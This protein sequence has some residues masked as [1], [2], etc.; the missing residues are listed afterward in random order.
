MLFVAFIAPNTYAIL[1]KFSWIAYVFGAFLLYTGIKLARQHAVEVH[2]E[3]NPVLN[4]IRRFMPITK[5]YRGQ[6]MFVREN[7]HRLATP[8]FAVLIVIE[9]TDVLFAVDSIPAIFGVTR[10]AFI[11]FTSNALALLGLRALYFLLADLVARFRYL[12]QGLAFVLGLIGIKLIYE[13][14]VH[15]GWLPDAL[16]YHVPTWAPLLAV[17]GII[18]IAIVLSM[19]NPM[20]EEELKDEL[21]LDGGDPLDEQDEPEAVH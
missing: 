4:F 17:A 16:E 15:A 6:K 19:R 11:V 5:D 20:D 3:D 10:N 7:G 1:A 2:P 8:L 18:G 21:R 12:S 9:T 14:A 13:E